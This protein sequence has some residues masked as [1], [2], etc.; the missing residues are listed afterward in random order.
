MFGSKKPSI[1]ASR[2]WSRSLIAA[3]VSALLA[4]CGGSS[5]G[6]DNTSTGSGGGNGEG[7]GSGYPTCSVA[8]KNQ[9]FF[10]YMQRDYLWADD[11]PDS[12]DPEAY[13]DLTDLL[14]DI[15]AP[16]DRFSYVLTQ[17]EYESLF[18]SAEYAG[19]GFS[20]QQTDQTTVKLRYV[21]RDS[22]A[23]N[24]GM[25]RA[26]AIIAVDGVPTSELLANGSYNQALGPAEA[27][28]TK[29]LTWRSPNG[30]EQT[31]VV[32]KD[33]VETNTVMGTTVWDIDNRKVGYF[34][35]DSFINRTGDDLN[36][37]FDRFQQ[38]AVDALV[39]DLRYNSGGLIRYAN[40]AS[41]QTAGVNVQGKTFVQYRFNEQ[42]SSNNQSVPF[43]LQDGV[44]QLDLDSVIVLASNT[45]C[46]S[47][48]LIINSLKPHIDVTV[49]GNTTCG[50]PVG[51][52]PADLC[53][54]KTF[55]IN[56]ETVN[57][58]GEGRYFDG[59]EPNC[60]VQDELVADWGD[61]ADPLTGAARDFLTTGSC[62]STAAADGIQIQTVSQNERAINS[63]L[64]P[65]IVNLKQK[66]ASLQ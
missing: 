23:W 41:T 43:S 19:F 30:E 2:C 17:E 27:G 35:L 32:S 66:R 64:N 59:I 5:S 6:D 15:K 25:R 18:V 52:V 16:Q 28:V 40:Q 24:A 50:K 61:F 26:D 4:G 9:R 51:Q 53:D 31:A 29:E 14:D 37:A 56:F 34:T 49:I 48:E 39:I 45:S 58:E 13:T 36:D 63:L 11:L 55:A 38:E 54:M 57:S 33:V 20:Q 1:T 7:S 21:Y 12:I 60:R 42:N 44:E 46:S 65:R 3:A 10:E 22:P 47:S 8:D 62:P